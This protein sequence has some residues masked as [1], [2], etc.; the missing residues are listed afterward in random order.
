MS[1]HVLWCAQALFASDDTLGHECKNFELKFTL[2]QNNYK[3][4][5]V[6]T[7]F[8]SKKNYEQKCVFNNMRAA[9]MSGEVLKLLIV[10]RKKTKGSHNF[11]FVGKWGGGSDMEKYL[12]IAGIY[13]QSHSNYHFL[14][15]KLFVHNL[16]LLH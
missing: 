10:R 15:R 6:N 9:K 2:L 8:G 14:T 3:M 4:S 7:H 11:F 5:S 13:S 1:L 12:R 16:K